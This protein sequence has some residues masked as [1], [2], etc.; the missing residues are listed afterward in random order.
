MSEVIQPANIADASAAESAHTIVDDDAGAER[1]V[2]GGGD[3]PT[4]HS[5]RKNIQDINKLD[6]PPEE[7]SRRIQKLMFSG[8]P[9]VEAG[10]QNNDPLV[11][12]FAPSYHDEPK[13]ILGCKHY[14]RQAKI[15]AKCCGKF[16]T[17]RLCHDEACD[18]K[19]DRY[20]T[21]EMLCMHCFTVQP[22]GQF[23]KSDNEKCNGRQ[24]A[25]YYC[26]TCR[27][28]SDADKSIFHCK[29]CGLCRVGKGLG[30]D[31]K[32]C[33][34]CGSCI[35]ISIFDDHVCLE[36]ALHSDCPICAEY[37]FTSVK[38]VCILKCGHYI[39]LPC[40]DEY[41]QQD[42]RCPICL[43]SL[44][45]MSHRWTQ[46][47]EYLETNPM[48]EEYADKMSTVLCYDCGDRTETSFHFLYHK[49]RC[50]SYNTTLV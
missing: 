35:N 21:E 31:Y 12:E 7:K 4:Q 49:C 20:A 37:M 1:A 18:H 19:I 16:F 48:P 50:G 15:R 38:P 22:V 8:C 6:I 42:Y 11:D 40:L 9:P 32:H 25:K 44:G 3:T 28:F 29:D 27:L 30:V 43:K 2:G 26:G 45:D 46:L 33:H 36:N 41:T 23:C 39:H 5:L 34:Q 24:L 13:E 17:C 14:P 47:D 10:T